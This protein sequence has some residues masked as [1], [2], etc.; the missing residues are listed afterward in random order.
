MAF[1]TASWLKQLVRED[2]DRV[3]HIIKQKDK[4]FRSY[5]D[6]TLPFS[7][8]LDIDLIT[9]NVLNPNSE[10]IVNLAKLANVSADSLITELHNTY[11]K[12]I[13]LYINKYP[14]VT[15]EELNIKLSKLGD[16]VKYNTSI[17]KV[18]NEEFGSTFTVSNLSKPDKSVLVIFP[19]FTTIRIGPDFKNAF[20]YSKFSDEITDHI[21]F[22][23]PR[24]IIQAY[25]DKNFGMLQNV[26]HMEID[27]ISSKEGSSEVKRGLVSPRLLQALLELP[28][29]MSPDRLTRVFSKNTGQAK[30]RIIVRKNYNNT[31][32][33][34]EM[35]IE[36]GMAIGT[37]E[38]RASNLQKAELE[39]KFGIGKNL[40]RRLVENKDLLPQLITSRSIN[41]QIAASILSILKGEKTSNNYTSS[42]SIEYKSKLE[43]QVVKLDTS[44]YKAKT[45]ATL[46]K[47]TTKYTTTNIANLQV[48][49]QERLS[50]QVRKNMG[51]GNDKK[52]LNYRSGRLANSASVERISESRAGM[53]SIFYNY[54]RNPYATFSEGGRQQY[55]RSRDPKLLI[56]KSIRELAMP[57]VG[58]RMRAVLV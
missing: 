55:P 53:V 58:S 8:Y 29:N 50:E 42:T 4:D 25:L 49:L 40:S 11:K 44:K 38:S 47:L 37:F 13:T 12:L 35:L 31:K 30:T 57:I 32:L 2:Q 36:A 48:L 15:S 41:Q 7:L 5:I 56:S 18:F 10:F 28:K 27:V 6:A 20:D 33:V 39:K 43:E 17:I 23:S 3:K 19:K 46:K 26:G 21:N 24:K 51:T 22:T 9:T 1:Y 45:S 54:M 16:A 52:I 14:K 34:L